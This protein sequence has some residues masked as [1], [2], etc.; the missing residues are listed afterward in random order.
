[1]SLQSSYLLFLRMSLSKYTCAK[2]Y[3]HGQLIELLV[4]VFDFLKKL[5]IDSIEYY[6]A[7]KKK[8]MD[9]DQLIWKGT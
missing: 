9:L 2:I 5:C 8:Q 4:I 6:T 1:M 3:V 7:I